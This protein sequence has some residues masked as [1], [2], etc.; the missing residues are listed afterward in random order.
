MKL[1]VHSIHFDAD[2]KLLAFIQV[3][4]NKLDQFY[5]RIISGEV[6]LRLT[7]GE[8]SKVL[9]KQIDI[10]INVPGGNLFVK[11]EG[12]SFEEATDL[13]VE[14]LKSQLRRFKD[15]TTDKTAPGSQVALEQLGLIAE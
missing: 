13:A 10:K 2:Q 3:K 15:K 6:F 11:E 14:A 8:S 9:I 1:Q 12:R 7:K 4:L 5:D